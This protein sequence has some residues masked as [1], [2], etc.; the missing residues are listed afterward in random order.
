[1]L[2]ESFYLTRR[3]HQGYSLLL[4]HKHQNQ[5]VSRPL[6]LQSQLHPRNTT[7]DESDE[8]GRTTEDMTLLQGR[9]FL[10]KNLISISIHSIPMQFLTCTRTCRSMISGMFRY[11]SCL[12]RTVISRLFDLTPDSFLFHKL[13]TDE[14]L[15]VLKIFMTFTTWQQ[16]LPFWLMNA[17]NIGD[18]DS[19]ARCFLGWQLPPCI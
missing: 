15:S 10:R 5:L 19:V 18:M 16:L 8:I 17:M 11:V 9:R 2:S 12:G 14:Q 13:F 1:M 6:E 7:R 3:P 4:K